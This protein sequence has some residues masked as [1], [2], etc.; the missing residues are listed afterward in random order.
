MT[1]R[2]LLGSLVLSAA[3]VAAGGWLAIATQVA[4]LTVLGAGVAVLGVSGFAVLAAALVW[5]AR[6][7]PRLDGEVRLPGLGHPVTIRRDALGTPH[8]EAADHHD[9]AFGIG[10][11]MAQDRL[12]QMDLLRRA[13][14][15]RLAE[16]AGPDA[17][18][19]DAYARTI[20]LGRIAEAEL[21]LLAADERQL[22]EGFA[23]G[24]NAVID[25]RV[26]GLPFEFRL[27]RYRPQRWEVSDSLAIAK[28]LGWLLSSSLEASALEGKLTERIGSDAAA[29]LFGRPSNAPARP[30]EG[31]TWD[32]A[33]ELDRRLRHALGGPSR[34][35]GSNAWAV[36]GSRTRS[37]APIL[38]NDIHLGLEYTLRLYEARVDG[39]T[40]HVS[41]LFVPGAPLPVTGT[42]GRIAWGATNTG[43]AV[44]DLYVEEVSDDGESARYGA[45][46]EP[47][48]SIT[49]EIA[50]RG[51]RARRLTVRFSRHGPIVSDLVRAAA[52][53][54]GRALSIRWAGAETGPAAA[55]LL[56]IAQAS[57]WDEF[58]AACDRWTVPATTFV[59]ADREGHV[60]MRVAGAL[61]ARPRVGLLPLDGTDRRCE[62]HGYLPPSANPRLLDPPNGWVATANNAPVGED[63]PYPVTWLPEP[64]YRI[65]RIAEVLDRLVD[66]GAVGQQE[67]AQLQRDTV[68]VQAL[69]L[70]P[71][72]AASLDRAA[73][74]PLESDALRHLDDWNGNVSVESVAATIWE[75]WY[76]H[77]LVGLLRERLAP[78]ELAL[79]LEI[80]RLNPGPV[81]WA[82]A[83]RPAL[84]AWC[85]RTPPEEVARR[86][87]A[88]AI[89]WLRQ[90]RGRDPSDWDWGAL[91]RARWRHPAGR[92]R[93][94]GWLLNRGPYAVPGD[95]V[96]V[97]AAEFRLSRPYEVILVPASRA[98]FDLGEPDAPR[99]STH[100]GQSGDPLSPHYDDR[101]SEFRRG[102]THVTP[103]QLRDSDTRH[104]LRLVPS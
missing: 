43:A 85:V 55:A 20:G 76:Q 5:L 13:A 93:A 78:D 22:L 80:P 75:A 17:A 104:L 56:R 15:G 62:W 99:F 87:F 96:T 49:E 60:G 71:L 23:S 92:S 98:L 51:R 81:P 100:P 2:R 86:S 79:A 12:W 36:A 10:V 101:L 57:D 24:V 39:G 89:D 6:S 73:L 50:V 72:L 18:D 14:S 69:E 41:G 88:A 19:L 38:A 9:A 11:A 21:A 27:L 29:L 66:R 95:A 45:A 42:N 46:W 64:P 1:S 94:M 61:P 47:L 53:A 70:L 8:V 4:A 37:G 77:W 44:S 97:N 35:A 25:G 26:G 16:V 84:D 33:L 65:R 3:F 102:E 54:A 68:S 40:L 28:A 7:R 59:Y 82:L 83:D 58:N 48:G 74:S 52:P 67:M 34:G 63:Y 90:E 30:N 103:V 31:V 91:H 32:A